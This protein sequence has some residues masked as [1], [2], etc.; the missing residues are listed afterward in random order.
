MDRQCSCDL[1][2]G[3]RGEGAARLLRGGNLSFCK[4]FQPA[5]GLAGTCGLWP[6]AGRSAQRTILLRSGALLLQNAS[7]DDQALDLAGAVENAE[8]AAM[9]KQALDGRAA[10][11]AET[12]KDLQ[13]LVDDLKGHFG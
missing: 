2:F 10:H 7:R 9:P 11:H 4:L 12:A 1:M 6:V 8:G 3:T 5:A 13:C